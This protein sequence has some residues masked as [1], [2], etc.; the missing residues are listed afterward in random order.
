MDGNI[1]YCFLPLP[2]QSAMRKSFF[3]DKYMWHGT[4]KKEIGNNKRKTERKL[5]HFHAKTKL[6]YLVC[7]YQTNNKI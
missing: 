7:S 1:K 5:T 6:Y 3:S 2:Q 4:K